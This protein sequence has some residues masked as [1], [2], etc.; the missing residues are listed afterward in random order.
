MPVGQKLALIVVVGAA[1]IGVL[2]GFNFSVTRLSTDYKPG[3]AGITLSL[4]SPAAVHTFIAA[5]P[6]SII[7]PMPLDSTSKVAEPS[8]PAAN[9]NK[10]A[11]AQAS[12]LTPISSVWANRIKFLNANEVD[13]TAYLSDGFETALEQRLPLDVESIM[14]EFW[15]AEDGSTVQVTCLEGACSD[16]VISSLGKLTELKFSPAIKSK[17]AVASRKVIQIDPKPKFGL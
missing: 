16:A 15:I 13:K 2:T 3:P 7:I 8:P 4:R 17:Q 10:S 11:G 5:P 12:P 1:H 6:A 14:L 9:L